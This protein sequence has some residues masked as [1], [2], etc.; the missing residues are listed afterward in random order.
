MAAY[1]EILAQHASIMTHLD[2][3]GAL[4]GDTRSRLRPAQRRQQLREHLT[5]LRQ[6]LAPHF[7]TEEEGGYLHEVVDA[8]PDLSRRAE[9][10]GAQHHEILQHIDLTLGSV[11]DKGLPSL[12]ADAQAVIDRIRD[13]E[14]AERALIQEAALREL[15]ASD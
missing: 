4:V 8:R 9:T 1:D 7:A 13:H 2:R 15:S 6:V 12:A 3:L 10:I 14:A 11:S 5:A